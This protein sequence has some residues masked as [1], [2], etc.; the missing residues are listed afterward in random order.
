MSLVDLG[1]APVPWHA[2]IAF[3]STH[4]RPALALA[5]FRIAS[6]GDAT[7]AVAVA[8]VGTAGAV[9]PESR[10]FTVRTAAVPRVLAFQRVLTY[11]L[12]SVPLEQGFIELGDAFFL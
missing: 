5:S 8:V 7:E 6:V 4:T 9:G 11:E 2:A 10:S 1:Q 3:Q 12:E